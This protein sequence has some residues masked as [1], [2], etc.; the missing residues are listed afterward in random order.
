MAPAGY[1]KRRRSLVDMLLADR[2]SALR[3]GTPARRSAHRR[4][5]PIWSCVRPKRKR[6]RLRRSPSS[7]TG[8]SI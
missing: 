8:L 3:S 7:R 1:A 5:L 4:R 6:Q 2:Q